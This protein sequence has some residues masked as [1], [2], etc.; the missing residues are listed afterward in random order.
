MQKVYHLNTYHSLVEPT[1]YACFS[2]AQPVTSYQSLYL[3]I[4]FDTPKNYFNVKRNKK[5][6]NALP[7]KKRKKR[8]KK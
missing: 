1:G 8:Q 4:A 6:G 5:V 2:N 7:Q 3:G